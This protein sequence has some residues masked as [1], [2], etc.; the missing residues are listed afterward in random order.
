[1]NN[2]LIK[3]EGNNTIPRSNIESSQLHNSSN[4]ICTIC[5]NNFLGKNIFKTNCSHLFHRECLSNLVIVNNDKKCP[6]CGTEISNR[7]ISV[8]DTLPVNKVVTATIEKLLI[9]INN[10][11]QSEW[12]N[13][14]TEH[15]N[16]LA[17]VLED[18]Y[19]PAN[20]LT[21]SILQTA[22]LAVLDELKLPPVCD[23]FTQILKLIEIF[24]Q[25]GCKVPQEKLNKL[26][27][28]AYTNENTAYVAVTRTLHKLGGSLTQE[29]LHKQYY[30]A[31]HFV[32]SSNANTINLFFELGGKINI[33][34]KGDDANSKQKETDI[35]HLTC[36]EMVNIIPPGS[37][38]GTFKYFENL[39][40]HRGNLITQDTLNTCLFSILTSSYSYHLTEWAPMLISL[41]AK[42]GK[43]QLEDILYFSHRNINLHHQP[44]QE[45][46]RIKYLFDL[47]L[48]LTG[49]QLSACIVNWQLPHDNLPGMS[50]LIQFFYEQGKRI[51]PLQLSKDISN[52]LKQSNNKVDEFISVLLKMGGKI[53]DKD[54]E[55][56]ITKAQNNNNNGLVQVLQQF[57][58]NVI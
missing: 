10:L 29:Q 17:L 33:F 52:V 49:K 27:L 50:E 32:P 39:Y 51:E 53:N 43:D 23:D 47:G 13:T 48:K 22:L 56:A 35:L 5:T 58:P 55:E 28:Y 3:S 15:F 9:T 20:Q 19:V 40:T 1:M 2:N 42:L 11:K 16:S 36:F 26:L 31:R 4:E 34:D 41:N 30:L 8:L 57:S 25:L 18:L 44:K 24:F 12:F 6:S 45:L 46:I 37:G 14:N 54:L 21:K 7:E 38:T